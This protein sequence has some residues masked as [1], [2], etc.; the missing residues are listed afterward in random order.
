MLTDD[1]LKQIT[2]Q[3]IVTP[4]LTGYLNRNEQGDAE[5][6]EFL[7]EGKALFDHSRIRLV[8]MARRMLDKR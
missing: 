7:F 6:F 2:E 8:F 3:A 4:D 1:L 5:L